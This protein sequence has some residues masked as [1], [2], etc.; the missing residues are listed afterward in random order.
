MRCGGEWERGRTRRFARASVGDGVVG[1]G[2]DEA[3]AEAEGAGTGG[4][5]G[6][7]GDD[8]VDEEGVPERDQLVV[9]PDDATPASSIIEMN[10]AR[11]E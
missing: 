5:G 4:D 10:V 2:E 7:A 8:V 1:I 6:A 3:G 11:S 9:G